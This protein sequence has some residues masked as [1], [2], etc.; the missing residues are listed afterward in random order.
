[1]IV[2]YLQCRCSGSEELAL[3]DT[4][5]HSSIKPSKYRAR[6]PHRNNGNMYG[7]RNKNKING[8][9]IKRCTFIFGQLLHAG[10]RE[11]LLSFL[12]YA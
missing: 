5:P 2:S 10:L 1:M 3:F 8:I 9:L 11:D 6:E 7:N 4:L 12:R